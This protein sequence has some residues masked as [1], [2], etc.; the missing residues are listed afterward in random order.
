MTYK[1]WN[2]S[3]EWPRAG[4][5]CI[6]GKSI[7]LL[8]LWIQ[9]VRQENYVPTVFDNFS[10]SVVVDGQTVSLG[11]WDTAEKPGREQEIKMINGDAY[12]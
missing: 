6:R 3:L 11:L 5:A 7:D 9:L 4:I 2:T 8:L 10:A 12:T 1:V